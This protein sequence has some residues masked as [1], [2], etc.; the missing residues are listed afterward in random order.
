MSVITTPSRGKSW[1]FQ[2]TALCV[3]LG[4]LLALSLKTQKQVMSEGGG[5]T[6]WPA[7]R[8]EF[9]NLK[10]QNI[11]LQQDLAD[12]KTR[13]EKLMNE[14]A[15]SM[16]GANSLKQAL[17][18]MKMLAGTVAVRGRGV[19][20]TLVD[21]PKRDIAETRK[22]VI[23]DYIVHDYDLRGVVNELFAAGAEA[24][25]INNQRFGKQRHQ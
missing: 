1:L 19:I 8:A 24:I 16:S 10:S 15:S 11:K 5:P 9:F 14:Q 21:S 17:E 13:Y 3:V 20:V 23:E 6:R 2:V 22:E 4:M 18:E 7:L 25:S 12:Y